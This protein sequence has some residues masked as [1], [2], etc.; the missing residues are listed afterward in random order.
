[1][2]LVISTV[3]V[4]GWLVTFGLATRAQRLDWDEEAESPWRTATAWPI[5]VGTLAVVIAVVAYMRLDE[6]LRR[7]GV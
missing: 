6:A 5:I 3:Y 4:I 2:L 7:A 1:M